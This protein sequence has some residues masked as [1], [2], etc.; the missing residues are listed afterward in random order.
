[1]KVKAT[2][3]ISFSLLFSF[4]V[5]P[6]MNIFFYLSKTY[7]FKVILIIIQMNNNTFC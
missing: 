4:Y 2:S 6:E 1:M 7:N 5:A 3:N